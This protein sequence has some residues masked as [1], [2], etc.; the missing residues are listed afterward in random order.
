MP[1]PRD[2][3]RDDFSVAMLTDQD[4]GARASITDRDHQ[5][6]RV[7]KGKNNVTPFPI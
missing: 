4:M 7:P 2:D 1:E 6:L 5:L 3:A